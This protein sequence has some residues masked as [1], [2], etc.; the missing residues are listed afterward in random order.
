MLAVSHIQPCVSDAVPVVSDR[1]LA[2]PRLS[3]IVPVYNEGQT[4]SELLRQVAA[5]PYP[6]PEKEVVIV[7]DGSTDRTPEVVREWAN[8]P[9]FTLLHHPINRGKG[10]A[11]RTGLAVAQGEVVLVQDADLE[12]DPA[13]YPRLIEPILKGEARVVYGSRYLTPASALPWSKFRVAVCLLNA[14]VR[15]LYGQRLTD[16]ATCYKAIHRDLIPRLSLQAERFELC[17]EITAKV[18]RLGVSILEVPISYTPRQP[19]DG[20][21]IGWRDAFAAFTTL[22][23][24]RF[25]RN[26]ADGRS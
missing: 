11:V 1:T 5:G 19:S 22:V 9:G 16:E 7:D 17:S 6:F 2:R 12:Y 4:I 10:A 13:D 26:F 8:R 14:V 23:K 20:K 18:C 25:K 21:K 24:W 15:V 3:V